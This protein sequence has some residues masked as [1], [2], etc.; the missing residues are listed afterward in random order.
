[1]RFSEKENR[2]KLQVP[3]KK[4]EAQSDQSLKTGTKDL[5]LQKIQKITVQIKR[6]NLK[7][8]VI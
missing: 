8:E 6:R 3:E 2:H 5:F 7:E 4:R 1:M